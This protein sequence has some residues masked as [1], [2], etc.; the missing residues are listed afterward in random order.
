MTSLNS[1]D[2]LSLYKKY[3]N[4]KGWDAEYHKVEVFAPIILKYIK[5]IKLKI[6]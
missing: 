5:K 2:L 6:T 1:T 3:N 4:K